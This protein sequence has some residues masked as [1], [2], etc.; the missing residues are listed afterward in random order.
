[1]MKSNGGVISAREVAAQP[2]TA[3]ER[4]G[5]GRARRVSA[6]RAAGFDRV[7]TADTGGTSTD[8]CRRA[9]GARPHYRR[10]GGPIPGQGADDRYR[11]GW[12]GRRRH[13]VV[14]PTAGSG[15]AAQ[16][17]DVRA[18]VTGA[19]GPSPPDNAHLL[20][21]RIRRACWVEKSARGRAGASSR[22]SRRISASSPR[23]RPR[24]F[25]R[26]PPG[27][28]PTRS[29]RYRSSA[30]SIRATTRSWPS[31]APVPCWPDGSS[32]SCTCAPR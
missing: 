18:T 8:V 23:A 1:M 30:G 6:R 31:A 27:T 4:P 29:S 32:I 11:H 5:G 24:A 12:R 22:P 21:G 19:V 26:S 16:R 7:L 15:Q 14:A 10:R 2:I 17:R 13:R 20:L 3:I 9:R 25:S 28:R